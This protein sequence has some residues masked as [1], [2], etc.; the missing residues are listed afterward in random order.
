MVYKL[1]AQ[2]AALLRSTGGN[3][4]AHAL[5]QIGARQVAQKFPEVAAQQTSA[6][7]RKAAPAVDLSLIYELEYA[8]GHTFE[9]VKTALMSTGQ[10]AYVEPL[11]LREPLHQPNDPAADS[12]KTTQYYLKQVQAYAGWAAEKGDTNI[13]IGVLDTGFRLSHEDLASKVKYNYADPVDGIDND[14]D[15]LIDNY[16]GWDFAD[17]DN[18]VI[19]DTAWKGHGTAVAGVA[20]GATNNGLGMAGMGYNT[21]FLPLKVFSSYSGGA[22]G[23]F[24]AI[25]YAA[26]KGCKVINLS[27]GGTCYS[28]FEQDVIDYAV[29]VKDVLIIASGG[30]TNVF[31]DYYPASYN[32][33]VSVGGVNNQDVKFRDHTYSYKIDLVSPSV[34][35]YSTSIAGDNRYG[36]VGGTSFSAPTVAGGAALVRSRYPELNARQVAERLR[37]SSDDIYGLAG[38]QAYLE[39]LGFGRFNLKK[40]LKAEGLKAVRCQSFA[41]SPLQSLAAGKSVTVDASF[42]N[43]LAPVSGLQVTLSSLSP[44]VTIEQGQANLGALSTMGTAATGQ[45]PFVIRIADNAP[46]NQKIYVRL[47]FSDGTYQDFQHFELFIN[48]NFATLTANNLHITLNSEGNIG[49][50]G[51]NLRQGVGVTYKGGSSLLFEG[52]LMLATESGVVADNLHNAEWQNDRNFKPISQARLYFNTQQADQEIRSLMQTN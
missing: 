35:I 43:Y 18:N 50:N 11:Y 7:A 10:V 37:V 29:L 9:Q 34:N 23:G 48:P 25:V 4:M 19:D 42:I 32:H 51:L 30:N 21:K 28:E 12:T 13:V 36:N 45:N 8:S 33:V 47:G 15:G 14:G 3:S 26:N 49:Y 52:G 20:A 27:W 16:S 39:M 22:F 2:Q 31:V 46:A 41:P 24:E 44:Y 5:Q 38:N 1:K 17:G 40:A 6:M